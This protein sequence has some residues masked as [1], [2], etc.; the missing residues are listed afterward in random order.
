MRTRRVCRA[1]RRQLY[2]SVTIVDRVFDAGGGTFGILSICPT[3]PMCRLLVCTARCAFSRRTLSSC[4]SRVQRRESMLQHCD[5]SRSIR[6]DSTRDTPPT[7]RRTAQRRWSG[8]VAL[9]SCRSWTSLTGRRK[10]ARASRQR[11]S[12]LPDGPRCG[13]SAPGARLPYP[14]A[15][16]S[17]RFRRNSYCA[18]SG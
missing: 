12:R 11:P 4:A 7:A 6:S 9:R 2:G 13:Q 8:R 5:K 17:R 18:S 1:D 10:R 15:R 3:R 16:P 14:A